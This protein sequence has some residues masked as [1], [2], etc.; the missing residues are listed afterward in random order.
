[1]TEIFEGCGLPETDTLLYT[2]MH[3]IARHSTHWHYRHLPRRSHLLLLQYN[4]LHT[5]GAHLSWRWLR[6]RQLLL[7]GSRNRGLAMTFS[8]NTCNRHPATCHLL[9]QLHL[10]SG[11]R[12]LVNGFHDAY[13]AKAFFA[14]HQHRF[15]VED[16]Q[17]IVI[18]LLGLLPGHIIWKVDHA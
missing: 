6:R 17:G 8:V 12:C 2:S 15:V 3:V 14:G 4:E 7:I 10:L 11:C 16:A 13:I 18:H 5:V 1:M 9:L